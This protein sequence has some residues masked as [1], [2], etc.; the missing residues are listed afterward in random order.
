MGA[1]TSVAETAVRAGRQGSSA[2]KLASE[3]LGKMPLLLSLYCTEWGCLACLTLG[4][5]LPYWVAAPLGA[6]PTLRRLR[7]GAPHSDPQRA[8]AP[9]KLTETYTAPK[10]TLIIPSLVSASLQVRGWIYNNQIARTVGRG[11]GGGGGG[12]R[13][14]HDL[15]SGMEGF[16]G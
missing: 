12:G 6:R 9:F 13:V 5:I 4:A 7:P 1:R 3:V 16:G 10:G 15:G 8:Q 2:G 11:G 14:E